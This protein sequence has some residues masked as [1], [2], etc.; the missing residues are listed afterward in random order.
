MPVKYS[1]TQLLDFYERVSGRNLPAGCVVFGM[2]PT[3]NA[4]RL[5]LRRV[6]PEA[7][8]FFQRQIP[9]DALRLEIEPRAGR[10]VAMNAESL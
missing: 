1:E 8:S 3:H 6:D 9:S 2:D 10:A 4:L 7:V 5:V